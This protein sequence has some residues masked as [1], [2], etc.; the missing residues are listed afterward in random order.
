MK[1]KAKKQPRKPRTWVWEGWGVR[2]E[3]SLFVQ[4]WHKEEAINIANRHRDQ[5]TLVRVVAKATEVLP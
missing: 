4:T 1:T 2:W 5:A 3:A